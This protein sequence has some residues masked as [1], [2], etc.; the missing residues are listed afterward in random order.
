LNIQFAPEDRDEETSKASPGM[1]SGTISQGILPS[2]RPKPKTNMSK[3][4]TIYIGF[5]LSESKIGIKKAKIAIVTSADMRSDFRPY[6][7]IRAI[8]TKVEAR[9]IIDIRS[10]SLIAISGS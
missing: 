1:I 2:P 9:L 10:V 5:N 6:R 7:S 3:H 8:D 4:S